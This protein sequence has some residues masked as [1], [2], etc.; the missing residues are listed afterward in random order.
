MASRRIVILGTGFAGFS[1]LR[2][3]DLHRYQ[4]TVVSPRNHFL[5]TPLLPS[6]TVGTIE[7]RSIIEP[8]RT[9]RQ[10]VV[11]YQAE[12][13]A[14][15]PQ[16]RSITCA[17]TEGARTFPL[18]YDVLVLAVGAV[19]AT[20][21]IPGVREHA[22]F[23]RE[24][25]DARAI[26][27]KVIDCFERASLPG[28]PP[29]EQSR[30]LTIV[31]VGA[32]PTGVEFAAELHDF[33]VDD[34]RRHY[35]SVAAGVR[36]ILLEARSQILST[37]D[38]TL[39]AYTQDYFR[40]QQIEV[41]TDQVITSVDDRQVFLRNCVPLPYGVLVWSTGNGPSALI[42][43]LPSPKEGGRVIVDN[44]FRAD[45]TATIYAIGDC[46]S[47]HGQR[48]PA[49]A[50]V[51]QQEGVHLAKSLNREAAGGTPVP[52]RYRDLGMLAYIGGNKALADLSTVKGRGY[53]AFIFW[54]S[55]YLT[56]LVNLKNKILVVFD[57]LKTMVFGRDIS[58][59]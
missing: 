10:G 56:R 40:R 59:F 55:A 51:A 1:F 18:G 53:L 16:Q 58:R 32:G 3:I 46:A 31:I 2:K 39:S 6:T 50:Q 43:S 22:L 52:F 36:I 28:L 47:I 42:E 8:V 26:R 30:L 20:F 25:S 13:T 34:V 41:Q 35:P 9:A 29:D 11:Y 4:V 48:L 17:G 21:G 7:F 37:F 23:L 15:D 38:E 57:W 54:R 24:L 45:G 44:Y 14:I 12:C 27:Q 49:T 19:N 33:V 5:F